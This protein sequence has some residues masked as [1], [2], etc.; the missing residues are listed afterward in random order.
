MR[1]RED[2]VTDQAGAEIGGRQRARE[3]R[4]F[5]YRPQGRRVNH[6]R[7]AT[8]LTLAEARDALAR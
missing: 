1:W 8:R 4:S 2:V 7:P 3:R 5:L 6:E